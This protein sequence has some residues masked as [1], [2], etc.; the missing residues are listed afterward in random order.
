MKTI[1][2][3]VGVIAILTFA[4]LASSLVM[5]EVTTDTTSTTDT[6]DVS[7]GKIFWN[8]VGLFFTFNQEKKIEKEMQ[9]A[10]LRLKQAEYAAQNNMTKQAEKALDAYNRLVERA[11]KRNELIKSKTTANAD[12]IRLAAMDQAIL[13]HQ[14]RIEKL[15]N[16]L[17]TAN[18]TDEQKA[19]LE[20]K[21][22]QAQ[23]TTAHLQEVQT[24]KEEKIKTRLMAQKNITEDEAEEVLD[25]AKENA[26]EIVDGAKKAWHSFKDE[27]N[28]KNMTPKELAKQKRQEFKAEF[29]DQ[30]KGQKSEKNETDDEVETESDETSDLNETD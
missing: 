3:M 21:I 26:D 5:A 20:A 13:V 8:E 2:A 30:L 1:T 19:K 28:A 9:L 22:S 29:K 18:L 15:S 6:A 17:A 14:G 23:N 11:N 27:A 16:I 7:S 25:E 4:I 10:Q 24:E 12:A